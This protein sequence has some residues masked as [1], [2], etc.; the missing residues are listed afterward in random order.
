MWFHGGAWWCIGVAIWWRGLSVV[1]VHACMRHVHV[2]S[3]DV[4]TL[5]R[6]L[7]FVVVVV[8]VFGGGGE[9]GLDAWRR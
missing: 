6:R 9:G 7:Y 5:A 1:Y 2:G 4:R 3:V 8:V